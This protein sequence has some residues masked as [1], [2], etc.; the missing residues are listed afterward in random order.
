MQHD[1]RWARPPPAVT[2]S[3]PARAS[4]WQGRGRRAPSWSAGPGGPSIPCGRPVAGRR[5]WRATI[6]LGRARLPGDR[7]GD[8][9]INAGRAGVQ[10][11]RSCDHQSQMA[12]RNRIQ[13]P[14]VIEIASQREGNQRNGHQDHEPASPR[15]MAGG[16]SRAEAGDAALEGMVNQSSERRKPRE[17]SGGDY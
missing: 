6:P 16:R 17:R 8:E 15:A 4:V 13:L 11:C 5:A 9:V 10:F 2:V 3:P 1:A 12:R 14:V 7:G